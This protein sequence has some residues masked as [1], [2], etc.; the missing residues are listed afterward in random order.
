MTPYD[1]IRRKK[2]GQSNK[3]GDIN[4][5]VQ[6]YVDGSVAD[7]QFS[8]W[9]MAVCFNGMN[10]EELIAYTG[11]LMDSGERFDLSDI[12]G[13]KVDKHS[14]GGVG[15]KV[16][17]ALA[18]LVAACGVPVPMVS[19]RGLGHTGGTIDKLSSI[20][21]FRTDLSRG[22]FKQFLDK[23][24]LAMMG[25]GPRLCPADGMIYALRD[26]TAT[27]ESIPLIAAS[28][29]AKKIAEGAEGLVLDVKVG[30]GAFMKKEKDSEELAETIIS[31]TERFGVRTRAVLSDMS[32][33][34]GRAVGN[35]L[36]VAEAIE[37][38]GG[39]GPDDLRRLV[40]ELAAQML[41]LAGRSEDQAAK[42]TRDA[43]DSGKALVK[44]REMVAV[45]GGNPRIADDC[46]LLPGAGFK[47]QVRADKDGIVQN[48]DTYR[49]GMLGVQLGAGRR[50]KKDIID[51]GAGF[52]IEKK[53]GDRVQTGE[54]IATV[55]ANDENKGQ[56]I[57]RELSDCF[58]TGDHEVLPSPLIIK[59]I[60]SF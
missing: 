48:I 51:P 18:P 46:S 60:P 14:T 44:F 9:L 2:E 8:A 50:T 34:L 4:R 12:P 58:E 49:L 40:L 31:V 6:G 1:F 30:S 26:V 10:E 59:R 20:P 15:D 52:T 25:Q 55:H 42:E 17:L 53:T 33:P 29:S 22:E 23:T 41:I 19:G 43:L 36:E 39:K 11:A 13:F 24:G 7:Y 21:G 38:L 16:S 54:E 5:F 28:V 27:V 37:C 45:Q 47:I 35:A 32:Q 56:K 3:T 57:A